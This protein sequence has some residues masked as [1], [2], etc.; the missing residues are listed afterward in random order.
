MLKIKDTS[1]GR[2]LSNALLNPLIAKMLKDQKVTFDNIVKK[3]VDNI[4]HCVVTLDEFLDVCSGG[5]AEERVPLEFQNALFDLGIKIFVTD[6]EFG[7]GCHSLG[8]SKTSMKEATKTINEKFLEKRKVF[9]SRCNIV[10]LS[11]DNQLLGYSVLEFRPGHVELDQLASV[12]QSPIVQSRD[13]YIMSERPSNERVALLLESN[14]SASYIIVNDVIYAI[15]DKI[16]IPIGSGDWLKSMVNKDKV[17]SGDPIHLV[18]GEKELIR[19]NTKRHLASDKAFSYI[20]SL[21]FAASTMACIGKKNC[22][23]RLTLVA[24]IS[25]KSFYNQFAKYGVTTEY[26]GYST[27]PINTITEMV[28]GHDF[29]KKLP[30]NI[31]PSGKHEK[32]L[33]LQTMLDYDTVAKSRNIV[34]KDVGVVDSI[35]LVKDQ[36]A[37][38]GNDEARHAWINKM[39][40]I[41]KNA[42]DLQKTQEAER[43]IYN[44]FQAKILHM[45]EEKQKLLDNNKQNAE[46][47]PAFPG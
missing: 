7:L 15:E 41:A 10:A 4:D 34:L 45:R 12:S 25:A 18:F 3:E 28:P 22:G 30:F 16:T 23:K 11:G 42:T 24:D 33:Q 9:G 21:L 14:P 1:E 6:A 26:G 20:G 39:D 46:E 5:R 29:F 13:L 8:I 47:D 44:A 37:K 17:D 32:P 35:P 2:N 27:K 36:V 43:K 38:T 31:P 19:A 40:E